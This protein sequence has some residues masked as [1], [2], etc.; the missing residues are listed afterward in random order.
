[1]PSLWAAFC[2]TGC[3]GPLDEETLLS[4]QEKILRGQWETQIE[5]SGCGHEPILTC[6][7]CLIMDYNDSS[8]A[9]IW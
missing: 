2:K 9:F 7:G 8:K 5:A 3:G 1:M 4:K 6:Q